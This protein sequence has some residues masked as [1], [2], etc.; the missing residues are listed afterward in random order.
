MSILTEWACKVCDVVKPSS[1]YPSGGG[2]YTC[3]PCK[4][5]HT[6]SHT[7]SLDLETRRERERRNG[8]WK[9]YRLRPDEYSELIK[10]GC[11]VCGTHEDLCVDHDH[12]CCPGSRTCGKCVRGALCK[13]HNRGEACFETV[14]EIM[15]LLAYRLKY[16]KERNK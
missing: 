6:R 16:D 13:K 2:Q 10:D 14:D 7:R 4:A 11:A 15:E 9:R 3:K 5:A 1:E 8:L 12:S